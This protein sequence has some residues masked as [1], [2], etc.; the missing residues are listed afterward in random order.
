MQCGAQNSQISVLKSMSKRGEKRRMHECMGKTDYII[1]I[2][3]ANAS[4]SR[5]LL[6]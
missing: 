2:G 3:G 4:V 6:M 1:M 5:Q